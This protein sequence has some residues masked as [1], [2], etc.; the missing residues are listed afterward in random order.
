MK[1]I[2]DKRSMLEPKKNLKINVLFRSKSEF[3][4]VYMR[5]RKLV[6]HMMRVIKIIFFFN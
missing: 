6:S 1:N 5:I 4:E 3:E 2:N